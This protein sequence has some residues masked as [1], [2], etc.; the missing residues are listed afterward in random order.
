[1]VLNN[2]SNIKNSRL[3]L[4]SS[5][6]IAFLLLMAFFLLTYPYN[7]NENDDGFAYA[8]AIRA[9]SWASLFKSRY[10]LFLPFSKIIYTTV[11]N[12]GLTKADPYLVMCYISTVSAALTLL[13]V[14]HFLKKSV[15]LST[16]NAIWGTTFLL[17]CYSF[18][19]Y[20]VEAEVYS[21]SNLFC[22]IILSLLASARKEQYLQV[23]LAGLLGGIAVSFYKPNL[24]PLFFCF[25]FL[26]LFQRRW[27]QL[28]LYG[29]MG[30][31]TILAIYY[32]VFVSINP[33]NNSFS[34]F[35]SGGSSRSPGSPLM[36]IFVLL[37]NVVAT[38][39]LYGLP[40]VSNFIGTHFPTHVITE[41]I[42]AAAQ[43]G[44]YN[45]IALGTSVAL[46][47]CTAWIIIRYSKLLRFKK[48]T[49]L[50]LVLTIWLLLYALMLLYLDP[51]SPEPAMM[52]IMPLV[53]LVAYWVSP[54]FNAGK[55]HALWVL[56]AILWLHNYIGGYKVIADKKGDFISHN[57]HWLEENAQPDDLILSLGART[58]LAYIAYYT[59][60]NIISPEQAFSRS[61]TLMNETI[62]QN[63]KVYFMD[64]MLHP[65][66]AVRFRNEA[67][68]KRIDAF[69]S[70][71]NKYLTLVNPNDNEHGKVYELTY[72]GELKEE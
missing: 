30:A 59:P 32:W 49:S 38:G 58:T 20:A 5:Y 55:T 61:I 26:L 70:R 35:L 2:L 39:F 68:C 21:P 17:G 69:I 31:F 1:M 9:D 60:A 16:I 64:D 4:T 14:F 62:R 41:E 3:R 54:L 40:A 11:V 19:R 52:L 22:I 23:L 53:L 7:R 50:I 57:V 43:N 27:K 33:E 63:H 12:V 72:K 36:F 34:E 18:W 45:Y 13:F 46:I 51:T 67:V 28:F 42:Y 15:G 48:P 56:L 66:N 8:L 65:D 25:P 71:Y 44:P 47:I 24:I 29:G 37:G 6:L 10:L